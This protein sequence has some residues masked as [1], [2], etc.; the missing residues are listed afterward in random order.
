MMPEICTPVT[1]FIQFSITCP[2]C[3]C[4]L[5]VEAGQWSLSSCG[6]GRYWRLMPES[7]I[8]EE[9]LRIKAAEKQVQQPA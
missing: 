9:M 4:T 7:A 5:R 8:A 3:R 1:P 2:A 6:C